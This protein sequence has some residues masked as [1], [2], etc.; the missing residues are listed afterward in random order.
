M[1]YILVTGGVI[2]GLGKGVSTSSVASLL[3]HCGLK[4]TCIKIDPYL[5]VDPGTMSPYEHG[6]VYVLD[7]GGEVDLDL[8]TYERFLNITLSKD[9]NITAGKIYQQLI[10]KERKG[11]YLGKTVQVVPH[12]TDSVQQ[13]IERVAHIPVNEN[14][15][16]PDVCMIELGG[17]VGDIEGMMFLEA[18]RQFRVHHLE[19][20][21]HIHVSLVPLA[22]GQKSKPTQ[23]GFR[24]L[25]SQGL[26]PD[27]MFCRCEE[28]VKDA[29]KDKISMFCM[30][31]ATHVISMHNVDDIYSVP[32]ILFEQNVHQMMLE[33]L[34]W[35]VSGEIRPLEPLPIYERTVNVGV[36]GKYTELSDAYLSISKAFIHA[37]HENQVNVEIR[38]FDADSWCIHALRACHGIMV[39]G[40]FGTRGVKGKMTAIYYARD[41]KVPFLGICM[42]FQLAVIEYAQN[43]LGLRPYSEEWE[44]SLIGDNDYAAIINMEDTK[45][46]EVGMGGTLRLGLH[47]VHLSQGSKVSSV[48]NNNSVIKERHRHRFEVNPSLCEHLKKEKD[49]NFVF[50]GTDPSR[51]RMECLE[52]KDHPYFVASQFHPEFLSRRGKA[53]PLFSSLVAAMKE[54][55]EY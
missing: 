35:N 14:K 17:T 51:Q 53:S 19:D 5:N 10:Q 6:E 12:V 45:A 15:E 8:G 22:G 18:F 32:H 26:N 34:R 50:S 24:E 30:V 20:F 46:S 44:T 52:L 7:D 9:H 43:V 16:T 47:D 49:E 33:K 13:W 37:G 21:V 31:P 29:V 23:H 3:Q 40:G 38:W 41:E 36:V 48:Y 54:E 27:F 28:K 11:D 4:V 42:G 25:G 55:N 1:K 39:P 2:S